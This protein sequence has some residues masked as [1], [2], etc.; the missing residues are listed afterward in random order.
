M[1]ICVYLYILCLNVSISYGQ[2]LY[3]FMVNLYTNVHNFNHANAVL[4][5]N[6]SVPSSSRDVYLNRASSECILFYS[7][8]LLFNIV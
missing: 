6:I 2:E 7:M 5:L 8:L 1:Y 3:H 4:I